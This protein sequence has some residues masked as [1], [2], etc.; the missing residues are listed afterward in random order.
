VGRRCGC[1]AAA[2]GC[3]VALRGII[4]LIPGWFQG[5]GIVHVSASEF[6][7]VFL[8]GGVLPGEQGTLLLTGIFALAA[9]TVIRALR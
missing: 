5:P 8:L 1:L 2:T 3:A 6:I 9:M 4:G 7:D